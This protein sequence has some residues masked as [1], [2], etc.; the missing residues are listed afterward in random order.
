ME[1]ANK[2]GHHFCPPF[3]EKYFLASPSKP[4]HCKYCGRHNSPLCAGNTEEFRFQIAV[5]D[6]GLWETSLA[7][8]GRHNSV[9][10][11]DSAGSITSDSCWSGSFGSSWPGLWFVD[12]DESAWR[13]L[14]LTPVQGNDVHT[15]NNIAF[16]LEGQADWKHMELMLSK[17]VCS[18]GLISGLFYAF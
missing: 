14:P 10:W 17:H 5:E 4:Q 1:A 8:A 18:K 12:L 15:G 9:M 3:T 7:F 6:K 11:S 2:V 13:G 16:S